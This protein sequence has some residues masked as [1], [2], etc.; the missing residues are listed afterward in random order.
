MIGNNAHV[1]GMYTC[2]SAYI[3]ARRG[4]LFIILVWVV[5]NLKLGNNQ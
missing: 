4:L 1:L 5:Q 3:R 2:E